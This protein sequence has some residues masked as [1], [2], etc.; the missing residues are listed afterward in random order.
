MIGFGSGW[1]DPYEDP[2]MD[3]AS[4]ILKAIMDGGKYDLDKLGHNKLVWERLE[5]RLNKLRE[6]VKEKK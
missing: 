6:L 4:N 5:K 2:F 3:K 1:D